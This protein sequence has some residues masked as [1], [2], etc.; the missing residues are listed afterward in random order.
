VR[1]LAAAKKMTLREYTEDA[2]RHA[3][4]TVAL[5]PTVLT[6]VDHIANA[7]HL[8][9]QELI[10]RV[11]TEQVFP[12]FVFHAMQAD[13]RRAKILKERADMVAHLTAQDTPHDTP[14]AST[15]PTP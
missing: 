8:T 6:M 14:T 3:R 13:M 11:L 5:S 1:Q 2:L 9:R 7:A 4:E 12:M 10:E 15:E